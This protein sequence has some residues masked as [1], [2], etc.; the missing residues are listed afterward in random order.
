MSNFKR[1]SVVA[2]PSYDLSNPVLNALAKDFKEYW[3]SGCEPS[4]KFGR[5][6]ALE[7]PETMLD[8]GLAK[9]H[10]YSTSLA[11]GKL[12]AW[13]KKSNDAHPFYRGTSNDILIYAVSEQGTAVLLA[14]HKDNG[15]DKMNDYPHLQT[16][17][18]MAHK[19]FEN[20]N[21]QPLLFDELRQLYLPAG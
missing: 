3:Q 9:V 4:F 20:R 11:P 21:E 19:V 13:K 17:R 14:Y 5:D 10:I 7:R 15:H 2:A 1:I 8:A 6:T 16:L 18:E 12:K